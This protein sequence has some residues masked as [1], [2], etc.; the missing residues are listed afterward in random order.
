MRC[1][2]DCIDCVMQCVSNRL[3]TSSFCCSIL[4]NRSSLTS[5]SSRSMRSSCWFFA[6]VAATVIVLEGIV[7]KVVLGV[8]CT[9]SYSS[10]H[11]SIIA[12][13][14]VA[15]LTVRSADFSSSSCEERQ[16]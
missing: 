3:H 13:A 1:K 15:A 12:A 4:A 8:N 2:F 6:V 11:H 5:L 7:A 10:D 9:C 14:V 16:L